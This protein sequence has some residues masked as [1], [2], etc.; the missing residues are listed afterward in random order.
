MPTPG[1]LPARVSAPA[2]QQAVSAARALAAGR[3]TLPAS[4]LGALQRLV[5]NAAVTAALTAVRRRPV[6]PASRLRWVV[7]RYASSDHKDLGDAATSRTLNLDLWTGPPNPVT[8][9]KEVT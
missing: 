2:P 1:V 7:Q 6:R 9:A 3:T 8:Q 4:S 5:G